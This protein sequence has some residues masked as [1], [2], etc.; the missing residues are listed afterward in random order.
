MHSTSEN[1]AR[2]GKKA[3]GAKILKQWFRFKQ[4]AENS[5]EQEQKKTC[6]QGD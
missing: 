4:S 3:H 5:N 6:T 1:T 2:V